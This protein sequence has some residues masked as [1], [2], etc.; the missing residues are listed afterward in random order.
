MATPIFPPTTTKHPANETFAY[1]TLP[2]TN[3][4]TVAIHEQ[5]R[6]Q[7]WSLANATEFIHQIGETIAFR[8]FLID[9]SGSMSINDG[10]K[11]YRSKGKTR[12]HSCSRW[13]ELIDSMRFHM[14]LAHCGHIP[15][16]FRFLNGSAPLKLGCTE[17]A[18]REQQNFDQLMRIC[19]GSP[20]GATPLCRHIHEVTMEIRQIESQLQACGKKVCIM[21]TTDGEASDGNI[22]EALR[23]LKQLPVHIML[24]LCTDEDKVINYW[25]A[26]ET[27]LETR[28]D[29]LDGWKEEAEEVEEHNPWLTYGQELHL[30]REFGCL[31]KEM[32]L[33]DERPLSIEEFLRIA[34]FVYGSET[35]KKLPPVENDVDVFFEAFYQV[36]QE[37]PGTVCP[38]TGEKRPWIDIALVKEKVFQIQ[39]TCTPGCI[40]M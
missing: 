29:V 26:V 18:V 32:D 11:V 20:N 9:D 38:Q 21:I 13:M 10:H 15:S 22:I 4:N 30:C 34:R 1:I 39:E 37:S 23:P 33:L 28:M 3:L 2:P 40:L 36:I 27:D 31:M 5:L 19:D 24:R 35:M 12:F 7:G 16:E 17:D 8:Y 25:N 6:G 14:K